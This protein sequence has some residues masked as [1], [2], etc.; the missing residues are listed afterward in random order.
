M[1]DQTKNSKKKNGWLG[2]IFYWVIIIAFVYFISQQLNEIEDVVEALQRGSWR[3]LFIAAFFELLYQLFYTQMNVRLLRE[4]GVKTSFA[5]MFRLTISSLFL[6]I[7]APGGTTGGMVYQSQ[8]VKEYFNESFVKSFISQSFLIFQT[9]VGVIGVILA[10]IWTRYDHGVEYATS[11]V[12]A[13]MFLFLTLIFALVY[14]LVGRYPEKLAKLYNAGGPFTKIVTFFTQGLFEVKHD[15][16]DWAEERLKA[17]S[18]AIREAVGNRELF[19]S[20]IV[21]GFMLHVIRLTVMY[22]VFIAFNISVTPGLLLV[23]YSTMYL[24]TIISPTPQG[25]GIAEGLAQVVLAAFGVKSG[26][27]LL[28]VL[29]YRAIILWIPMLFGLFMFRIVEGKSVWTRWG[30]IKTTDE[31]L[32]K[33]HESD[34]A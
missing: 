31:L 6:N 8:K 4:M 21:S 17:M 11:F 15:D 14:F 25:I 20:S 29:G 34:E 5:L 7:T 13:M 10:G 28:A 12:A 27:A 24:F 26:S 9:Y 3:F 32:S 19:W 1:A 23:G 30:V 22:F 2:K 33:V 18:L 16:A